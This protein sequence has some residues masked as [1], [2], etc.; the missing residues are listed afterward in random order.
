[1]ALSISAMPDRRP[2][3]IAVTDLKRISDDLRRW[4]SA[5]FEGGTDLIQ[6]RAPGL[7]HADVRHAA[8]SLITAAPAPDRIQ[9]NERV[10]LATELGC[11]IH[12]P[13]R[14]EPVRPPLAPASRSVHSIE[15]ARASDRF[16]FV[17][18]GHVFATASKPGLSPRGPAWLAEMTRASPV[19]VIAIGG[20]NA[21]N[22][23]ETIAHGA[24]GIAVIGALA[25]SDQPRAAAHALR[26]AI[27]IAWSERPMQDQTTT[28]DIVLNGKPAAIPAGSTIAGLLAEKELTER[29]VVVELNGAIVPRSDFIA[30]VFSAGDQVEIVHFVGGGSIER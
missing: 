15:S 27:D 7:S 20:I 1:M 6:L 3:L 14:M 22:A 16:D 23:A 2:L 5:L 11:G 18:A 8:E 25:T 24:A 29:L 21:D 28:I 13:E 10:A 30:A 9:I 17:V 4:A 19:P 26:T 12:L